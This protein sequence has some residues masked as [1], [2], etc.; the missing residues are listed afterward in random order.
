[1]F[2]VPCMC[3]VTALTL[4][5][6]LTLGICSKNSAGSSGVH[7]SLS[8]GAFASLDLMWLNVALGMGQIG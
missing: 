6:M 2:L 4:S 7:R 3:C 5:N 1:M 8:I